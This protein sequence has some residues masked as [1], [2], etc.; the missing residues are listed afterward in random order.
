VSAIDGNRQFERGH[1][2]DALEHAGR[3]LADVQRH[4]AKVIIMHFL[5]D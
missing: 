3:P 1:R 5:G 4:V 2:V